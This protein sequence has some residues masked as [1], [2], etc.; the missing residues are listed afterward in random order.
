MLKGERQREFVLSHKQ[1]PHYLEACPQPLQEV[2]LLIL[3][4]GMRPGEACNLEW[5]DVHLEPAIGARYGYIHITDGKSRYAKRNLSLTSRDLV[6]YLGS[7]SSLHNQ[8]Q[9]SLPCFWNADIGV[10]IH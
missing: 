4:T 5:S 10:G 1:E 6:M 7:D 3:D 9:S 2:A 8:R